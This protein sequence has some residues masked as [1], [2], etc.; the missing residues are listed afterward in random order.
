M[1]KKRLAVATV[2]AV[3]LIGS[4]ALP[5][6][7]A[8][9]SDVTITGDTLSITS[10][11]VGNFSGV[12]LNGTARSATATFAPF[13]VTDARGTGAGWNVTVEATQFAEWETDEYVTSGKTIPAS[14]VSMPLVSAAKA[15]ATSSALPSITAGPYTIDSGSSVQL[16]SAAAD[17]TGMGSYT[18]SQGGSLTLSVPASA[19]ARTYRSDM[20]VSVNSGP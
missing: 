9:P 16:A 7:A 4:L 5:A 14:S 1:I 13:T 18:F 3:A 11:S 10:P 2:G 6:F 17:G 12:T 15:D 20:T 8:D 19:Y